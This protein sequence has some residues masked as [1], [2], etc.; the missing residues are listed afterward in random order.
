[1]VKEMKEFQQI[2]SEEM[3]PQ[4]DADHIILLPSNGTW[5]SE[6]NKEAVQLLKSPFWKSVPAV[7]KGTSTK[8][9]VLTGKPAPF[10]LTV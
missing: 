1:M 10:W 8:W 5:A 7:K 9:N 6:E 3:I 4:I 2:I